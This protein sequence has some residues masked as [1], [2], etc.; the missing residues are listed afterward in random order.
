MDINTLMC[1]QITKLF[2][3]LSGLY[4]VKISA[5][6]YCFDLYLHIL[7]ELNKIK[8][9]VIYYHVYVKKQCQK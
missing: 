1:H 5:I 4:F 2:E 3:I 8:S 9:D 7:Q 6:M